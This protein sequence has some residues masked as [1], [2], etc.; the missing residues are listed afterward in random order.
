MPWPLLRRHGPATHTHLRQAAA[1]HV[2]RVCGIAFAR[3]GCCCSH[4]TQAAAGCSSSQLVAQMWQGTTAL[5][6]LAAG[7]GSQSG[8]ACLVVICEHTARCA[9]LSLVSLCGRCCACRC[10]PSCC[11]MQ[12]SPSDGLLAL[13][14][15]L[16]PREEPRARRAR[17]LLSTLLSPAKDSKREPQQ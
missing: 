7:R 13:L 16:M 11:E 15:L 4:A 2:P 10:S 1:A 14:L 17:P 5:L 3:Q 8:F 12:C 6:L 9:P